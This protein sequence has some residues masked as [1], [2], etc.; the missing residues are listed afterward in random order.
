MA[1]SNPLPGRLQ[2][3]QPFRDQFGSHPDEVDET[4]ASAPLMELLQKRIAGLAPAAAEK[5]LAE[6][7]AELERWLTAP[8]QVNDCLHFA[9]GFFLM[10]PAELVQQIRKEA[11]AQKAP[12]PWVEMELPPKAKVRRFEKEKDG[13]MLVKWQGLSFTAGV[14][15]RERWLKNGRRLKF[16]DLKN[17]VTST[18]V[19]FGEVTGTKYVEMAK[20]ASGHST[21]AIV[22][23]LSVPGGDLNVSLRYEGTKPNLKWDAAKLQAWREE[24]WK[25]GATWDEKPVEALFHTLRIGSKQL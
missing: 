10:S 24:Q 19:Q 21:K 16:W 3:L 18:P 7:I 22:Y 4:A 12:L 9:S 8:E 6:D 23:L 14:A 25:V 11:E 2:Y 1:R 15:N 20:D 17:E 5:L 13:G